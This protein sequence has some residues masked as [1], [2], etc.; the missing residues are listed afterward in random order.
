MPSD[1]STFK[2]HVFW[3]SWAQTMENNLLYKTIPTIKCAPRNQQFSQLH[4]FAPWAPTTKTFYLASD[5]SAVSELS[6]YTWT[7]YS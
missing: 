1:E 4:H 2:S 6:N 5:Y 3:W 7:N